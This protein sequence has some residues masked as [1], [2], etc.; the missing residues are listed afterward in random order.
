MLIAAV[1]LDEPFQQKGPFAFATAKENEQAAADA[2]AGV[3]G[4]IPALRENA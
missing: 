2:Q 4:E 1:P 3:F